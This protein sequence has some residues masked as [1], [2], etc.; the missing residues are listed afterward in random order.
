[1]N[2]KCAKRIRIAVLKAQAA[3]NGAFRRIDRTETD[4][5]GTIRNKTEYHPESS[6]RTYKRLKKEYL[7]LPYHRRGSL[8]S[9][10]GIK[11]ESHWHAIAR[12]Y[13]FRRGLDVPGESGL[14]D[15]KIYFVGMDD[16]CSEEDDHS[17]FKSIQRRSQ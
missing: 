3:N 6:R 2:G 14:N 15:E 1:M 5:D 4:K 16:V 8:F 9:R 13:S 17:P 11:M 12:F 7:I 10:Y